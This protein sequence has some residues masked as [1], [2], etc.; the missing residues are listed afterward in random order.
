MPDQRIGYQKEMD[1]FWFM[2]QAC[3]AT[4]QLEQLL[5][6]NAVFYR[7]DDGIFREALPVDPDK[8]A[9]A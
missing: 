3:L 5:T 9:N 7:N 4:G 2:V 6:D 1:P 8:G